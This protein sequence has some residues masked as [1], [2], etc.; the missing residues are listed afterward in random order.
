VSAIA[1]T[2]YECYFINLHALHNC[3]YLQKVLPRNLIVPVP[4]TQDR[5]E[6]H[7]RMAKKLQKENPGK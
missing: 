1:H 4:W 3:A 7:N 2:D 6:L 5:Q